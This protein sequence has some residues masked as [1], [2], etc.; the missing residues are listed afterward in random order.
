MGVQSVVPQFKWPVAEGQVT[1]GGANASA[2]PATFSIFRYAVEHET[3]DAG[4]VDAV[5]PALRQRRRRIPVGVV[6]LV[7]DARREAWTAP[8]RAHAASAEVQAP[9]VTVDDHHERR[10]DLDRAKSQRPPVS[11]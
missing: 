10:H 4:V 7:E 5:V 9:L 2:V 1:L 3:L 11:S 6:Q 8:G